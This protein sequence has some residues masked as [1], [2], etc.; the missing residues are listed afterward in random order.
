MLNISEGSERFSRADK[1]NFYVIACGS[2]FECVAIIDILRDAGLITGENHQ[3]LYPF[4]EGQSRKL[5]GIIQSLNQGMII[6]F[7]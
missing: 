6:T 1:R 5:W 7:M 4:C 2:V 3:S